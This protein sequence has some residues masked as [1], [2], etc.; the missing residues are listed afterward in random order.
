MN[1]DLP[2]SAFLTVLTMMTVFCGGILGRVVLFGVRLMI[3]RVGV[4]VLGVSMSRAKVLPTWPA[5][6]LV[7]DRARVERLQIDR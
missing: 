1:E 3:L 5:W 6:P 7:V 4:V 2:R